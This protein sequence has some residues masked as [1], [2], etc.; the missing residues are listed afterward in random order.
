MSEWHPPNERRTEVKGKRGWEKAEFAN[1]P[2]R[3][4]GWIAKQLVGLLQRKDVKVRR[5]KAYV[6]MIIVRRSRLVVQHQEAVLSALG[7]LAQDNPPVATK[8]AKAPPDQSS[9]YCPVTA[10]PLSS[11]V[12]LLRLSQPLYL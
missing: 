10:P 1:S 5:A 4:G 6:F 9:T 3:Q 12:Q 2:S 8:L 11:L 7:A